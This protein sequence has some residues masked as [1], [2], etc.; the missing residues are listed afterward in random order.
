MTQQ[1]QDLL[2][3]PWSPEQVERLAELQRGERYGHPYTCCY[4]NFDQKDSDRM[5]VRSYFLSLKSEK[6]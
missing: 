1:I 6:I 3:A 4:G 2:I 5:G